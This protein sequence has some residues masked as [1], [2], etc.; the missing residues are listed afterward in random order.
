M[1]TD[2]RTVAVAFKQN[3]LKRFC[4]TNARNRLIMLKA[5]DCAG[6]Y[7]KQ[8]HGDVKLAK[9]SWAWAEKKWAK[10]W[11]NRGIDK[12]KTKTEKNEKKFSRNRVKCVN[13]IIWRANKRVKL[14]VLLFFCLV[15][16]NA[17]KWHSFQNRSYQM[18]IFSMRENEWNEL[19]SIRSEK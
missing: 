13:S 8:Q 12:Q 14:L 5:Q 18:D 15:K 7:T 3:V 10:C 11:L 17:I 19:F 1:W 4:F 9:M 16:P 2:R 6:T